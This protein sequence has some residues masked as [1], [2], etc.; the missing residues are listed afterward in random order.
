M[1]DVP[2]TKKRFISIYCV[3]LLIN[4][5]GCMPTKGL[6]DKF[7]NAVS[8][9]NAGLAGDVAL[10]EKVKYESKMSDASKSFL[11]Q[12]RVAPGLKNWCGTNAEKE[13]AIATARKKTFEAI[14]A[15]SEGISKKFEEKIDFTVYAGYVKQAIDAVDSS[16]VAAY[17]APSAA[18]LTASRN[19]VVPVTALAARLGNMY[20]EEE[21]ARAV[22]KTA[23]QVDGWLQKAVGDMAEGLSSFDQSFLVQINNYAACE[24]ERLSLVYADMSVNRKEMSEAFE[25]YYTKL[26]NLK[27]AEGVRADTASLL[28]KV[29]TAHKALANPRVDWEE[30]KRR[31][32]ELSG[33]VKD[34]KTAVGI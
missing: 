7:G 1:G 5:G 29:A 8:A 18:A 30:T 23:K 28:K 15:Y 6:S 32:I 24:Q 22:A 16:G 13:Y 20:Q 4:L 33:V 19:F 3:L 14:A 21:I 10:N 9:A 27:I 11:G 25:A 34:F 12:P 31:A 17:W 26:N 2:N